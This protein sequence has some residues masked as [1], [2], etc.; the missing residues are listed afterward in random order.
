MLI[1]GIDP[2]LPNG[3]FFD[4]SDGYVLRE[5]LSFDLSGGCVYRF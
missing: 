3:I 1:D 5:V 4:L 2:Y